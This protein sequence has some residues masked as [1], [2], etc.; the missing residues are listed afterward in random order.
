MRFSNAERMHDEFKVQEEERGR[1]SSA[2]VAPKAEKTA[3]KLQ[4][5]LC[6][7]IKACTHVCSV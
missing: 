1:E 5:S 7:K 2:V 6:L 3:E 4:S